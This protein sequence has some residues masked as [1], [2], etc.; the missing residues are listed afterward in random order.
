[1]TNSIN[2]NVGALK[3]QQNMVKLNNYLD[4]AMTCCL[5]SSY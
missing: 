4:Q 5:R 1:M 2:T 3:A